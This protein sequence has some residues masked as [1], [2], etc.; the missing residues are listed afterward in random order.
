M[1]TLLKKTSCTYITNKIYETFS[2]VF[3]VSQNVNFCTFSVLVLHEFGFIHWGNPTGNQE[4]DPVP[5]WLI[6]HVMKPK[7]DVVKTKWERYELSDI[8]GLTRNQLR[9][10]HCTEE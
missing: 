6:S 3:L 8:Y 7:V 2:C 1:L 10:D 4:E 9:Y 5:V